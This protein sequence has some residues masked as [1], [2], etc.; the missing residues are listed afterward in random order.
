VRELARFTLTKLDPSADFAAYYEARLA[1]VAGA[2]RAIAFEA[3]AEIAPES[4]LSLLRAALGDPAPRVRAAA[5]AGVGRLDASGHLEAI[6]AALRDRSALVRRAAA[7][8][9]RRAR[10]RAAYAHF[11]RKT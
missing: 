4:A 2:A 7:P 10:G 3:F 11:T 8:H 5:I 9:A 1:H 6:E